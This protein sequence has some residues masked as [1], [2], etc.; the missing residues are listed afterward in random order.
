MAVQLAPLALGA[1]RMAMQY[2][3]LISAG[4]GALPGI[5]RGD[6]GQAVAGGGLGYLGGRLGRGPLGAAGSKAGRLAGPSGMG[7]AARLG[8][9]LAG[10]AIGAPLIGGL[11]SSA[12]QAATQLG[13]QAVR[14]IGGPAGA[15]RV[16]FGAEPAGQL[17]TVSAVP[18]GSYDP[19][20]V[21]YHFDPT[22]ATQA[23]VLLRRQLGD[24]ELRAIQKQTEY[25][26][27]VVSQMK[28][29][30]F[31]RQMAAARV[32]QNIATQGQLI[33]QGQVGAQAMGQQAMG[34]I[35]QGLVSQYQYS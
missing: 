13:G 24:E 2:L 8:V 29:D 28:K 17:P 10:A 6:L 35:G 31:E 26:Y 9:P 14:G 12:G 3:P 34:A 21:A 11:A 32:R 20:G 1:G 4:F 23:S 5:Q 7:M 15:A 30:E 19:S 33:A 25:M 27:P 22:G 18:A 16:A